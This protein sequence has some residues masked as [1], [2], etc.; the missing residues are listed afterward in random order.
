[1]QQTLSLK[2]RTLNSV[3][4]IFTRPGFETVL[5][6][7]VGGTEYGGFWSR[8]IPDPRLYEYCTFRKVT[9]NGIN[10]EL[11]VS[12]LMQWYVYWDLKEKQRERLYSLVSKDAII[13]DVGTNVG[14]TLLNFAKITGESGFV[15]GFE[16]D[17]QNFDNAKKNMSLNVFDNIHLFKIGISDRKESVK[18]FRVDSHN[19][20]MNRILNDDEASGFEDFTVIETDTLDNLVADN[21]IERV[22]LIKIDIEGYEMRALRGAIATLERFKPQLF[23]E[24]GYTRLIKNDT[25]PTEMIVLLKD[26][27]YATYHAETDE[28]I[29]TDYDFSPLGDGGIDVYAIAG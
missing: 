23:I 11:D 22:D 4:K 28:K 13:F 9:R 19:L 12:C 3:R 10:Y 27:G 7:A 5:L 16:P 24:V 18:L 29:D 20:G 21:K 26:L 8:F 1:M 15:Y 14:E 17:E 6:R 2:T 25:S